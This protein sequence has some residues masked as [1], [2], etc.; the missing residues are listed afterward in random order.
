MTVNEA[1]QYYSEKLKNIENPIR[2]AR[3][4]ISLVTGMTMSE[5]ITAADTTL[6][7]ACLKRLEVAAYRRAA[8]EPFAYISGEKEFLGHKF[9]VN[10]NVL[11]PRPDT[12]MLV[13][14]AAGNE[15]SVLDL[16][17]GSG[18]IAVSLALLMP[19]AE[20]TAVDVSEGAL[21]IA[22][23][24]AERYKADVRFVKKD[25]LKR[26]IKFDRKFEV[27]VCNP[28]Y[29]ETETLKTL[30][31]DVRCYE[32]LLALDGGEDG[33]VFYRKIVQDSE[34]FLYSGGRLCFE[35]GYNQA[36]AVT[37]IMSEK[38][39]QIKVIKDF[40]GQDRV[41]MGVLKKRPGDK[42]SHDGH[43]DRLRIR[44]K[45]EGLE[46][47]AP[48]E[49]LEMLLFY[50]IPM[51]DVNE[52]SHR[53][54]EQFGGLSGVFDA[55][56]EDLMERG[57]I[58]LQT[59]VLLNLVP[60]LIGV[61]NRDKWKEKCVLRENYVQGRFAADLLSGKNKEELYVILLDSGFTLIKS[62]KIS[63][64]TIDE[65][66]VNPRLVVEAVLRNK[67]SKVI[68]VHNHPSGS[69]EPSWDDIKVTKQIRNVLGSLEIELVEHFVVGGEE[70]YPM[71]KNGKL[72]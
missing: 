59:A 49:V 47:F 46:S 42:N 41:V 22:K 53:L 69:L 57:G 23:E 33:L 11:I 28:P 17:T 2:E 3:L 68:L 63:E 43:R 26:K 6:N 38:F 39:E 60:S 8:N 44:Y 48:H 51:R 37:K 58:S 16:C 5:L 25:I 18:C 66:A 30:E 64:G 34:L 15:R 61:Y 40:A 1:V 45:K 32:P 24:N 4:L 67:A 10:K 14:F 12:E 7:D 50:A 70:F 52:I 29:I 65:T 71:G 35:I 21:K 36:K 9:Y 19:W 13:N 20:V 55:S 72:I 54:I 62:E 56:V 31:P 27:A